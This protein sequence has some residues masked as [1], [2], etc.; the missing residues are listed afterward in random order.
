MRQAGALPQSDT[1]RLHLPKLDLHN[2][3]LPQGAHQ[4]GTE[5]AQ[6]FLVVGS[7]QCV[8]V[9]VQH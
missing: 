3:P 4:E 5:G 9:F 8:A 1:S 2:V 7:V 6:G